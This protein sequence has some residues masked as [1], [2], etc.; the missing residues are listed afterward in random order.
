[1]KGEEYRCISLGSPLAEIDNEDVTGLLDTGGEDVILQLRERLQAAIRLNI[2]RELR[3]VPL[4]LCVLRALLASGVGKAK[5]RGPGSLLIFVVALGGQ[6]DIAIARGDYAFRVRC[7]AAFWVARSPLSTELLVS[8]LASS[9][10]SPMGSPLDST[11]LTTT[12]ELV[13][14]VAPAATTLLHNTA[15]ATTGAARRLNFFTIDHFPGRVTFHEPQQ[16]I[17]GP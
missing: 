3:E 9:T 8:L 14:S 12:G 15:D 7:A 2:S 11:S 17:G 10:K 16:S 6:V 4:L 5:N 1:M 13:T